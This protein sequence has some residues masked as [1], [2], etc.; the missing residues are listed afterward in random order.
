LL[1]DEGRND[2]DGKA[3][4]MIEKLA[5]TS[6][7]VVGFNVSGKL[8]DE[9]FRKDFLPQ[10]A[11]AAEQGE[12]GILVQFANDFAGWDLPALWD[13]ISYHTKYVFNIK[14]M[15]LVGDAKWQEWLAK[16]AKPIPI[17]E[18]RHFRTSDIDAAWDWLESTTSPHVDRQQRAISGGAISTALRLSNKR[19]LLAFVIAALSDALSFFT[20][21]LPP[22]VW[23]VDL[24]TAIL[25]FAVLGWHWILL[26]GLVMEAIPGLGVVPIWLLVVAA[27]AIWGTARPNLKQLQK[28]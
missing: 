2:A 18:I 22:V 11:A 21:P 1:G 3:P 8:R 20:T 19:L 5:R 10:I 24:L 28:K 4:P 12:I 27:I 9:D 13:E 17:A 7:S 16:L 15:A 26:P 25:L 23:G 6:Q 14:R